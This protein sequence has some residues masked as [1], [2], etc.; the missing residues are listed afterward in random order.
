MAPDPG[1]DR[2]ER[3]R[4][5][6]TLR[7]L[8]KVRRRLPLTVRKSPS[9]RLRKATLIVL[10][11]AALNIGV[12]GWLLLIHG[13]T[14]MYWVCALFSAIVL[15][16]TWLL[17]GWPNPLFRRNLREHRTGSIYG[18]RGWNL[19]VNDRLQSLAYDT[20]WEQANMTAQCVIPHGNIFP[21]RE[22][23]CGLYAHKLSPFKREQYVTSIDGVA[24]G[25]V[26]MWGR[27]IEHEY[28][29]RAEHMAVDTL[30]LPWDMRDR[31]EAFAVRYRCRVKIAPP[32]RSIDLVDMTEWERLPGC[33][34]R[35]PDPVDEELQ[36]L[37]REHNTKG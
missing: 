16:N 4:L 17:F 29:W 9:P 15:G 8:R 3:A 21:F 28:G 13:F 1:L 6:W 31:A 12:N 33:D 5:L 19:T 20:V 27:I 30:F 26:E 2:S 36:A 11:A 14:G 25:I 24:L 22:C 32:E 34:C 7:S 10:G 18:F 35:F 23:S 37:V